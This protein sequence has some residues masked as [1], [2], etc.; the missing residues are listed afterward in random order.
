[1]RLLI[2]LFKAQSQPK[3]L[4]ETQE[5]LKVAGIRFD[6]RYGFFL[7]NVGPVVVFFVLWCVY[8]SGAAFLLRPE[9]AVVVDML[10]IQFEFA[11][12][13]DDILMGMR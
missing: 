10:N 7:V 6:M 13:C 12:Q 5:I 11:C 9:A 8:V 4:G 2:A 3:T 1:M